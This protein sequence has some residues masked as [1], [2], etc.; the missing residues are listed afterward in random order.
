[1][2]FLLKYLS[3]KR[4][5]VALRTRVG[6]VV[7]WDASDSHIAQQQ[8]LPGVSVNPCFCCN[9]PPKAEEDGPRT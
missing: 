1:M 7:Q 9:V 5:S 4:V 2:K 8:S 6:V 3:V